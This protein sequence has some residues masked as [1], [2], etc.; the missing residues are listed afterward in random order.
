MK[1]IITVFVTL[2]ACLGFTAQN[3][4]AFDAESQQYLYVQTAQ[5]AIVKP[6]KGSADSF[7]LTLKNVRPNVICFA[8]R[9]KRTAG[10]LNVKNFI[11]LW[12]NPS[13]Q[14]KNNFKNIAPNANL[15]G[16]KIG[17]Q[18]QINI[19]VVLNEPQYDDKNKSLIYTINSLKGGEKISAM[20]LQ[21]VTILIDYC[22]N[23][24][25]TG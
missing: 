11:E 9:P 25:F 12:L 1:K 24:P 18:K 7:T 22:A 17:T 14:N 4:F 5:S 21:N 19:P 2:L 10:M 16:I 3:C 13:D 8:E 23:C 15:S 20:Q 6:V